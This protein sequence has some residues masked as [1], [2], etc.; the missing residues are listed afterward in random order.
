MRSKR[1]NRGFLIKKY[2]KNYTHSS[3]LRVM[4]INEWQSFG[5]SYIYIYSGI[6]ML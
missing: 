1:V 4:A 2:I 3:Y 6:E 5:S